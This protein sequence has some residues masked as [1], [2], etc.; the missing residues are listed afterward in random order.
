MLLCDGASHISKREVIV[1]NFKHAICTDAGLRWV[2]CWAACRG[3]GKRE[4][5]AR[6]M[7]YWKVPAMGKL[8]QTWTTV[9]TMKR[10]W[11]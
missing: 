1:D 6:T 7:M 9:K 8:V 11:R 3:L 2:L 4:A 5:A 10:T